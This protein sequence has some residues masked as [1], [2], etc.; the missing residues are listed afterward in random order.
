MEPNY[1][2][3]NMRHSLLKKIVHNFSVMVTILIHICPPGM[4]SID[5][6]LYVSTLLCSKDSAH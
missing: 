5:Y 6:P 2:V 3:C 1:S 4:G